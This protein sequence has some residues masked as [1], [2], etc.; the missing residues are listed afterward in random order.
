MSVGDGETVSVG[1]VA[2]S[3]GRQSTA[4]TWTNCTPPVLLVIRRRRLPPAGPRKIRDISVALVTDAHC[5]FW[6]CSEMVAP[7]MPATRYSS[8]DV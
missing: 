3:A 2:P 8:R 4:V 5:G 6:F 7:L 1:S